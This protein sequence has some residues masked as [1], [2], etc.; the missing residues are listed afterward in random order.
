MKGKP[1]QQ[2][3]HRLGKSK[4][5]SKKPKFTGETFYLDAKKHSVKI[6]SDFL[7]FLQ[8][9]MNTTDIDLQ[10][11]KD[12]YGITSLNKNILLTAVKKQDEIVFIVDDKQ[13]HNIPLKEI[14]FAIEYGQKDKNLFPD[15]ILSTCFK[16]FLG[17]YKKEVKKFITK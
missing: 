10:P 13:I 8:D 16:N 4:I 3:L 9:Y 12:I 14:W 17:T 7:V 2:S 5:H 1:S 15:P 11:L 6:A